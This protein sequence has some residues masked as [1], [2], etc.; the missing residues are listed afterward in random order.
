VNEFIAEVRIMQSHRRIPAFT[1]VEQMV[2]A[3]IL[4]VATLGALEY[5][6]YAAA[7]GRIASGQIAAGR[8][9]HLLLVDWKSTGGSLEY[10]PSGLGLG[11]SAGRAIPGGFTTPAGL[12]TAL[13]SAVYGI[14]LDN[15]PMLA[16]LKYHDV[17]QDAQAQTTLRQ[18]AVI[19][20]FAQ[21]DAGGGMS[22]PESR[23]A[24]LAPTIFVTYVRLD[25]SDG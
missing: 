17:D 12:G 21:V 24:G 25:G 22:T 15:L 20:R 23:F 11:F 13:N 14:T 1:L 2:A 18:L 4:A 7:M 9:A 19:V 6:Y 16:M 8:I 5:Q 3:A 10:D